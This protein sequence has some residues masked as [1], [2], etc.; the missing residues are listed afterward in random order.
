MTDGTPACLYCGSTHEEVPLVRLL[1]QGQDLFICAQHLPVLIHEPHKL[2][3]KLP[4]AEKLHG[5]EH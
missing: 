3:G 2:V 4:G 1:A 5:H